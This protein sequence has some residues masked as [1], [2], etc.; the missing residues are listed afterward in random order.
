VKYARIAGQ[1][2]VFSLAEVCGVPDVGIGGY[3][4]RKRGGKPDRKRLSG[5]QMLALTRSVHAETKGAYGSPRMVRVPRARGFS[6]GKEK[7]GRPVRDNG[8]Y[9]RHKRRHEA[10]TDS[11]HGLPAA[12]SLTVRNFTPTAPNKVWTSD[13]TYLWADEGWLYPAIVPDLFGREVVGWSP[14]P[15]SR[16]PSI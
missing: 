8:I 7:V 6:A 16:S 14:K 2:K 15:S 4:A 10:A 12:D 1:V 5:S 9:A 11:K 13:T 3:R